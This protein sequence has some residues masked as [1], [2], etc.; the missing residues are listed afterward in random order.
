LKKEELFGLLIAGICHDVDHD[1]L[2][3]TFH[4]NAKTKLAHLAPNLPPLE[5]HHCCLSCDLLH[6]LL[7]RLSEEDEKMITHFVIDCIMATDMEQHK[8]FMQAWSNVNNQFDET[9]ATHRLLL[10]QMILKSADISNVVKHFEES[11]RMSKMLMME[12]H[13]QGRIEIEL[14]L[15]ISPMCNPNDETPLCVG[16]VGFYEFV[17]GPLMKQ[18]FAF[19]PEVTSSIEQFES[20]LNHWKAQKATW[21]ANKST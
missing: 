10:S 14:G 6:P 2:N 9:N 15:P 1:G 7:S 3:N 17:A 4:R 13:R 5:H 21:E 20:N 11:E 18:L 16:Q 12:T 8:Y 19:F